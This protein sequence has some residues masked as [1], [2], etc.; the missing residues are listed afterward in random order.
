MV[1]D[2]KKRSIEDVLPAV[3]NA[4][5]RIKPKDAS[6]WAVVQSS[7]QLIR[8]KRNEGASWAEISAAFREAGFPTA[9]ES[10]V[11]LAY[12][13]SSEPLKKVTKARRRRESQRAQPAA[14]AATDAQPPSESESRLLGDQPRT[15]RSRY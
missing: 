14:Q 12:K 10:N 6:M 13:S 9:T 5:A 7:R 15:L 4:L 2:Q 11:R 8:E 1:G 3:E